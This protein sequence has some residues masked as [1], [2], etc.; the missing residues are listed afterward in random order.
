MRRFLFALL[1]LSL[2]WGCAPTPVNAVSPPVPTEEQ[3]EWAVSEL[4]PANDYREWEGVEATIS[5]LPF[6]DGSGKGTVIFGTVDFV[7]AVWRA[8]NLMD[9][10]EL[11]FVRENTRVIEQEL[12]WGWT[13]AE[14]GGTTIVKYEQIRAIADDFGGRRLVTHRG[15][16]EHILLVKNRNEIVLAGALIHE[17]SHHYDWKSCRPSGGI[18]AEARAISRELVLYDRY[19]VDALAQRWRE[20]IGVHGAG[21]NPETSINPECEAEIH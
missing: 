20:R 17:A 10:E 16:G 9:A 2:L 11:A 18:E 21:R 7:E 14:R 5:I 8:F 6:E 3:I 15:S 19:N 13:R 4:G 12:L 1:A